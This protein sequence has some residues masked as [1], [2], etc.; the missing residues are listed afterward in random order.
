[1]QRSNPQLS[2][3]DVNGVTSQVAPNFNPIRGV[4]VPEQEVFNPAALRE[5]AVKHPEKA[6]EILK[7][8]KLQKE[9]ET[10]GAAEGQ[11]TFRAATAEE[12]TQFGSPYGQVSMK[13]GKFHKTGEKGPM[14]TIGDT[15]TT[16]DNVGDQAK[17][18]N[19][20]LNDFYNSLNMGGDAAQDTLQQLSLIHI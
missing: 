2:R 20:N 11:E 1:M 7:N 4:D 13:T 3:T 16:I 19:A 9:I 8:H 6:N 12:L 15:T 18:N 10:M 5:L 17:G 14:V